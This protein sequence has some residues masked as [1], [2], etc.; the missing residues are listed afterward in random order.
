M[1]GFLS[2]VVCLALSAGLSMSAY[3]RS[4]R[5]DQ[6]GATRMGAWALV[7]VGL[8]L[9]GIV[10]LG[11]KVI[12]AVGHWAVNLV[13]NPLVWAGI[14]MLGVAVL[15]LITVGLTGASDDDEDPVVES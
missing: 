7:P 2:F 14:A 12:D 6:R 10:K 1:A 15:V 5:G 9:A 4:Q 3:R 11:R 13:F 8:W